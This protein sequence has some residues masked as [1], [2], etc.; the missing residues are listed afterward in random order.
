M[1]IDEERIQKES[2]PFIDGIRTGRV[3]VNFSEKELLKFN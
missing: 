3:K 1:F 2:I